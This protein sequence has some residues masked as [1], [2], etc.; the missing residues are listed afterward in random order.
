M[1]FYYSDGRKLKIAVTGSE[2]NRN[3]LSPPVLVLSYNEDI[4]RKQ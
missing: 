1:M 3:N 4:L 2:F